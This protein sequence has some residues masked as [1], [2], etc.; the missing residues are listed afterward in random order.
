MDSEWNTPGQAV[1]ALVVIP[2]Y[3]ESGRLPRIFGEIAARRAARGKE[4]VEVHYLV[5]DDGSGAEECKKIAA[6]I[7]EH[8]LSETISLKGL[9]VN[10]GKGG[11]LKAGFEDGLRPDF[12]YAG[13][14]DAD[15][16]VPFSE[17]HEAL[18]YLHQRAQTSLA[19][20]VGSRVRILGRE[21]SRSFLRHYMSRVFATFVSLLF[22]VPMYDSQCGLKMFKA[23]VLR[24]YLSV[25]D[26]F[27]WVWDTELVLAMIHDGEIVHELPI[28]WREV[29]GSK[30]SFL[31]DPIIMAAHLI[32]FRWGLRRRGKAHGS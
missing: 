26:D 12:K 32:V 13:F 9:S 28:H 16:S 17:L 7:E 30:V 24:R 14:V 8:G 31:R 18:I 23:D 29:G 19:A 1:K 3:R 27:R 25:P 4:P 10:R 6:L 15:G 20:V 22:N 11:A 2:A 21:I 5:V